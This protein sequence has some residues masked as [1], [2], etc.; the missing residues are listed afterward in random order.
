MG[1]EVAERSA[2]HR[3][4]QHT[5]QR[6]L[7]TIPL[8]RRSRLERRTSQ[9]ALRA[10]AVREKARMALKYAAAASSS[11]AL[12]RRGLPV[13]EERSDH[14]EHRVRVERRKDYRGEMER[15]QIATRLSTAGFEPTSRASTTASAA[16]ATATGESA[17]GTNSSATFVGDVELFNYESDLEYFA[18]IGLG[19]PAQFMNVIL[20]TG[21]ADLWIAAD[22]CTAENGCE[23]IPKYY[24]NVSD[25]AM[26]TGT[27]FDIQYG[28][29]GFA[30][31]DLWRD[32][33]SLGGYNVSHQGFGLVDELSVDLLSANV[34]GLL[35]MG[36]SSL[37]ASG[38]TPF[39]QNLW[40]ADVLPFPGFA[41]SL[42]R[43]GNVSN[44]DTIEDGGSLTIGYLNVSLFHGPIHWVPIPDAMQ[45]YW[46]IPMDALA[47]NGTNVTA[48]A[49]SDND[50]PLV[51][52]DTGTTLIGGPAEDV[53]NLYSL[54]P[55]AEAATGA[56]AGASALLCRVSSNCH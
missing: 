46:L 37:A 13:E 51:A 25:S 31:G 43:Y 23:D 18:T 20:D 38:A 48:T 49:A 34:S 28:H 40:Q 6:Q 30:A 3:G 55:G 36:W 44:A 1:L 41:F 15:R 26:D 56:Y 10:W 39:W 5:Q 4:Q 2:Q 50:K 35:G 22:N 11:S 42:S 24:A 12:L 9:D 45:S 47:V 8:R 16:Q 21:S 52:I 29:G 14:E 32:Y 19:A 53:A 54:I 17:S 27:S 7:T 33:V